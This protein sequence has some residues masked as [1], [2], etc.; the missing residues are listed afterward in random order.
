MLAPK[1]LPIIAVYS[2]CGF[3]RYVLSI[4]GLTTFTKKSAYSDPNPPKVKPKFNIGKLEN[5]QGAYSFIL[6]SL[7][8]SI[9]TIIIL[10]ISGFL[11]IAGIT[12]QECPLKDSPL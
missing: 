7:S 8:L 4:N 9:P 2:R 11:F 5:F 12:F 10:G 1:E 3:V 6:P